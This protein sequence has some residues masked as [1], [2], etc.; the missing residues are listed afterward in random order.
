MGDRAFI[1][2]ATGAWA[3]QCQRDRQRDFWARDS[4]AVQQLGPG[5]SLPRAWV[6]SLV[7]E[8]GSRKLHTAAENKE[9]Q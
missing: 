5:L 2:G 4:P 9:K 7:G 6:Q 3:G 1:M 8:V